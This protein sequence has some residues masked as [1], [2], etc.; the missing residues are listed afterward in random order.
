MH[1]SAPYN[2]SLHSSPV[3]LFSCI[4]VLVQPRYTPPPVARLEPKRL[5][6]AQGEQGS[7]RCL[8]EG[9]ERPQ[10]TKVGGEINPQT[11][12]IRGNELYF[13][14]VQVEDRGVYV[15]GKFY[16]LVFMLQCE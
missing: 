11:T 12:S 5:D 16:C 13:Y 14:N 10:W 6:L 15:C 9:A 7:L 4:K 3:Y 2:Q 1:A 8:L